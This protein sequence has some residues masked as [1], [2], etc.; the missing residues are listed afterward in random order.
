MF[1]T[2]LAAMAC[3]VLIPS[4]CHAQYPDKIVPKGLAPQFYT[5]TK[6]DGDNITFLTPHITKDGRGYDGGFTAIKDIEI[7]DGRGKKLAAEDFRKRVK[8]GT[9]VLVAPDDDKPDP[10]YFSVLKPDTVVLVGALL[11]TGIAPPK[12][13]K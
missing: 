3:F 11:K 1:R 7:Y 5:I 10:A 9:V 4:I 12:P 8:V 2:S 6:I 13:E